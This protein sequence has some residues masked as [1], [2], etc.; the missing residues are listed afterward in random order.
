MKTRKRA[1][2]RILALAMGVFAAGSAFGATYTLRAAATT[3]LLPDGVTQ[4]PMWGFALVSYD[5]GAG[6][7]A[8]DDVVRVPGPG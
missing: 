6:P 2:L 8:G 3:L 1:L 7:V 5:L 4:I